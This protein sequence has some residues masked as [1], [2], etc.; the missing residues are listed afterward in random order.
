VRGKKNVRADALL[1]KEGE[2]KGWRVGSHALNN[3]QGA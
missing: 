3:V 2:E 1:R